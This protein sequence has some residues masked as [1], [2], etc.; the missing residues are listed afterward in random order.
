MHDKVLP[1]FQ[2]FLISRGLAPKKHVPFYAV[3]V[4]KFLAF[5][6]KNQGLEPKART[7]KIL[8]ASCQHTEYC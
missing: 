1:D 4:S 8:R 2:D 3:W 5:S 6:N 7:E